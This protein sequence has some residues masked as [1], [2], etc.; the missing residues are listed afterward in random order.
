M[1]G[2]FAARFSLICEGDLTSKSN[3]LLLVVDLRRR[4]DIV[5][6]QVF[7]GQF[8]F[9]LRRRLA[10][11]VRSF[12]D[13]RFSLLVDFASICEEDS[14]SYCDELLLVELLRYAKAVGAGNTIYFR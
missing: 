5:L 7:A 10:I 13:D 1:R 8:I 14:T 9:I 12:L 3:A 4:F 2:V 6:R 11:D